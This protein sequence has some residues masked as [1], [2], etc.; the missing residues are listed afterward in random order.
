MGKV[1]DWELCKRLNFHHTTKWYMPKPESIQENESRKILWSFEMQTDHLSMNRRPD[2]EIISYWVDFTIPAGHRVKIKESK[3]RDKYLGFA[4][5]KLRKLWNIRVTV[6]PI[7]VGALGMLPKGLE[8][9]VKHLEIRGRIE[10]SKTTA[11]L[12]MARVLR[13]VLETWGDEACCHSGLQWKMIGQCW[14]EKTCK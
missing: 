3:N 1:I 9:G 13:Q 2:L 11:L 8:R 5:E 10:T 4:R 6:I 7:G 14:C 12:E